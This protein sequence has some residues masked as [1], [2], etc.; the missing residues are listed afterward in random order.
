MKDR[1][2]GFLG[3]SSECIGQIAETVRSYEPHTSCIDI[4]NFFK[5]EEVDSVCI[6]SGTNVLGVI[7]KNNL[8]K[9][10]ATQYGRAIY[11][12]REIRLLY[13]PVFLAVDFFTPILSVSEKAMS[14]ERTRIYD[15]VVVLKDSAYYG[16]VSV[17]MLLEHAIKTEREC[18]RE[19]NPLTQ[20]P[21]N[22]VINRVLSDTLAY[23]EDCAVVYFDLNHFKAYNDVYGFENGDRVIIL[24]AELLQDTV[25]TFCYTNSFVGHIGGDDFV[26]V[27]DRTPPHV[28]EGI[29]KSLLHKFDTKIKDF[30]RK[31]DLLS[32]HISAEDRNGVFREYALTSLSA[33][34]LSGDFRTLPS[35]ELLAME[36]ARL[37]KIVK[38]NP[39]SSYEIFPLMKNPSE[40][41]DIR[42]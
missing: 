6:T 3:G 12:K 40:E 5:K 11:P 27:F 23:G 18:A 41:M 35:I 7:T 8:N 34:C 36:M 10:L 30:F 25:K 33:A 19:L 1:P 16:M 38:K 31:E 37:K 9:A 42:P 14:R 17:K 20:L 2:G 26:A 29:L 24:F 28:I 32:G 21:G 13:D 39:H 15:A 4:E 22:R